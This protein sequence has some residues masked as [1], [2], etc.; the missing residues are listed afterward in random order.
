MYGVRHQHRHFNYFHFHIKISVCVLVSV[1]HLLQMIGSAWN[2]NIVGI[3]FPAVMFLHVILFR[4]RKNID[5]RLVI[6]FIYIILQRLVI[7]TKSVEFMPFYLSLSTFLM[8]TSFFL[9]GL[10]SVDAFIYVRLLSAY[11]S[12]YSWNIHFIF[13]QLL[14]FYIYICVWFCRYQME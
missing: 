8:S 3:C 13:R 1:L 12:I 4:K 6:L 5:S 7:R 14:Y 11:F 2:D 10:F 9:Y